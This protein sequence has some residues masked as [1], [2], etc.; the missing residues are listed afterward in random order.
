MHSEV[1]EDIDVICLFTKP[2]EIAGPQVKPLR[3]R[4]KGVIGGDGQT[5]KVQKITCQWASMR[6][7]FRCYHYSI[8]TDT[9]DPYE[10]VLDTG[11]MQWRLR[12]EEP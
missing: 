2:T 4:R 7:K 6:G 12:Y 11:T 5:H 9:D 3:L 1:L 10:L 8:L